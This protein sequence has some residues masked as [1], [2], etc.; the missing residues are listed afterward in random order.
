MR[1]HHGDD[2]VLQVDDQR[3]VVAW[4]RDVP[5][6]AEQRDATRVPA[7]GLEGGDRIVSGRAVLGLSI[8]HREGDGGGQQGVQVEGV[9]GAHGEV[10]LVAER[11]PE[12]VQQQVSPFGV[13]HRQSSAAGRPSPSRTSTRKRRPTGFHR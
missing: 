4:H 3:S 6:L 11:R 8:E 10:Q 5:G 7:K 12:R 9:R 1:R 13:Q 2:A